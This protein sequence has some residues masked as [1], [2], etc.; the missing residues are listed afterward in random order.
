MPLPRRGDIT[1]AAGLKYVD[2][3]ILAARAMSLRDFLATP[4][5][6]SV[7]DKPTLAKLYT[8]ASYLGVAPETLVSDFISF[9]DSID[10][11]SFDELKNLS[12][13]EVVEL[14]LL[15]RTATPAI[16]PSGY[17]GYALQYGRFKQ[18]NAREFRNP[19]A[20]R[21]LYVLSQV[22]GFDARQRGR[23]ADLLKSP[24]FAANPDSAALTLLAGLKFA[25]PADQFVAFEKFKADARR[26]YPKQLGGFTGLSDAGLRSIFALEFLADAKGG[27]LLALYFEQLASDPV[28]AR[29]DEKSRLAVL[30][31]PATRKGVVPG[32][33]ALFF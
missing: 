1:P 4:E 7:R 3:G 24:A 28:F 2:A 25:N 6:R 21:E 32:R 31:T 18:G 15:A 5:A 29:L 13:L 27:Q 17:L 20:V 14:F 30:A 8:L 12:A 19:D 22:Q 23:T 10:P 26:R 11:Q 33:N 16:R 9:R